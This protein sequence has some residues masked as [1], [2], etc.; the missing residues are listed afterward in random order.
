MLFRS[1]RPFSSIELACAV[2]Q[3]GSCARALCDGDA[4][5][6]SGLETPH[7]TLHTSHCTLQTS[8]FAFTLHTPHFIS[9]HLISSELFSPHLSSSHLISSLLICHLSSCPLLNLSTVQPFSSHRSSSQLILALLHVTKL[10]LPE[11][12]LLHTKINAQRSFCTQKLETQMRLHRQA[13]THTQA[14]TRRK[15]L[16]MRSVYTQ[17][18]FTQRS[19]CT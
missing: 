1:I 14:C 12:S 4:L 6:Q 18:A 2:R 19:F 11:R 10:L 9:S 16:H 17:H 5:L 13:C 8:H 3:S 7:S 15:L